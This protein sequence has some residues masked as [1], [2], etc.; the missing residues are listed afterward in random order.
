MGLDPAKNI[1]NMRLF[2]IGMIN[3][4]NARTTVSSSDFILQKG[5]FP[6]E[7]RERGKAGL[8]LSA[9]EGINPRQRSIYVNYALIRLP[10]KPTEI[11]VEFHKDFQKIWIGN[12]DI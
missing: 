2:S 11:S 5:N 12:V 7:E 4:F 9:K 8:I 10:S 3:Y 1:Y 6:E